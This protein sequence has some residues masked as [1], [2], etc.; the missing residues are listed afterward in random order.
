MIRHIRLLPLSIALCALLLSLGCPSYWGYNIVGSWMVDAFVEGELKTASLTYVGDKESGTC[1]MTT[2]GEFCSG[3]Y[4]VSKEVV[5]FNLDSQEMT[6]ITF[7]GT[8]EDKDKM[9][10][11]GV[12]DWGSGT[13]PFTWSAVRRD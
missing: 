13:E 2:E 7:E 5:D 8:F 6:V 4:T 11:A 10:G 9:S 12:S 3:T 1:T